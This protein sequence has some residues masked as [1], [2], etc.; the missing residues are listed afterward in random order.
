M[1]QDSPFR[2]ET[3]RSLAEQ[4]VG[5][6]REMILN[7]DLNAGDRLP[8]EVDLAEMMGVSR[9]ALREGMRTLEAQGL[10]ETRAGVGTLVRSL[11]ADQ[12]V[13]P[14]TLF[15]DASGGTI[16][17]EEF[18]SVRT[19]LEVEIAAL[20]AANATE[21]DLAIL[22]RSMADMEASAGDAETFASV[23]A[24]FHQSLATMTGNPLLGLF[25][26]ALRVLLEDHI[27]HVVGHIDP[28]TDVLPYHASILSAVE[29]GDE[30]EARR[31]M[32]DH[33][34]QV[35]EN[36]YTTMRDLGQEG[37]AT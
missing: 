31:A 21:G 15:V 8:P 25:V 11:G 17:F 30:D 16:S 34:R 28:A 13:Q 23:D 1:S 24:S 2:L 32:K 10:L 27:R 14:L 29:A 33:L 22:R 18:H 12:L 26:G 37:T 20:A 9:T 7:G 6:I 5:R 19:I 4:V 3:K 35:A 36:Y